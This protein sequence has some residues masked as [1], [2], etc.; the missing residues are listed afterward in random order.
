MI[1]A[2]G[3][4][5]AI[6][7]TPDA[8][9]FKAA[10]VAARSILAQEP[11]LPAD[12]VILCDA[13]DVAPGYDALPANLRARIT[14]LPWEKSSETAALP[15]G[16]HV[17]HAAYRRLFLPALLDERY[18]RIVYLDSD[19]AIVRPGLSR[20]LSLP[21]ADRPVAAAI[22]MIFLK[23]FEDG[24]LT[25]EFRAYRAGLGLPPA[26]PYFNSG[27][28]VIDPEAWLEQAVTEKALAFL[29]AEPARCLFHDQSALNAVLRDNWLAVSPRYNFM[30]DFQLLDLEALIAPVVMH[31]VNH[32]KPWH[33][34]DWAGEDRFARIYREAFAATPWAADAM[35]SPHALQ[36]PPPLSPAFTA[37]R[38]RLLAYL[39]TQAFAD[40][41]PG[42][43]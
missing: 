5:A 43:P 27:L 34:P 2:S 15:L 20:L 13:G 42:W 22:D 29:A 38:R 23:D 39:R 18:R 24:P 8:R 33:F 14:L 28:L 17:T 21:L 36:E 32:P 37:F 3:R 11:D 25:A 6:C 10:I 4:R 19:I 1:P 7:L 9:Y 12:I 35:P 41:P 31:F 16:R 30:G 40:T 26:A